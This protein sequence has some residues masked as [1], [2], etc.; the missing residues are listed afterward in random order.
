MRALWSDRPKCSHNVSQKV[1][2]ISCLSEKRGTRGPF[3]WGTEKVPQR[4]CVTKILPNV[5]V[6]FLARFASNPL[7]YW[8]MTGNPLELFRKFF[9]AV[10]TIFWFCGSFLVPDFKRI[11]RV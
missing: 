8:V 9:G 10:R 4:K 1:K 6:N 11:K 7:F 2:R 3:Y 5:R